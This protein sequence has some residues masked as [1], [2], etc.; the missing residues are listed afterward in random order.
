M[1]TFQSHMSTIKR[2]ILSTATAASHPI[3]ATSKS[4]SIYTFK[5]VI[6]LQERNFVLVFNCSNVA[7]LNCPDKSFI[8]IGGGDLLNEQIHQH[9][10]YIDVKENP[11]KLLIY[12]FF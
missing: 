7:C 10:I 1:L 5:V 9:F 8:I 3:L 11:F 4:Q 2:P 6:A 12:M